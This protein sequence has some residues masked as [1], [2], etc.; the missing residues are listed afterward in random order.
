TARRELDFDLI[1][2]GRQ[3]RIPSSGVERATEL[4]RLAPDLYVSGPT[5]NGNGR[6]LV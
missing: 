2:R 3:T 4:Y 1:Q 6:A 5:T